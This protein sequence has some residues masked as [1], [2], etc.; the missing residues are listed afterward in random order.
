MNNISHLHKTLYFQSSF[1]YIISFQPHKNPV[2]CMW[3]IPEIRCDKGQVFM[4]R[5]PPPQTANLTEKIIHTNALQRENVCTIQPRPTA[6]PHT[7]CLSQLTCV[8]WGLL[9]TQSRLTKHHL[10]ILSAVRA[11]AAFCLSDPMLGDLHSNKEQLTC[12]TTRHEKKLHSGASWDFLW[13][14]GDPYF[15]YQGESCPFSL[16]SVCEWSILLL[17]NVCYC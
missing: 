11:S 9:P 17:L 7:R 1:T 5:K 6:I 13:W 8:C 4:D 10:L 12:F 14:G 16:R 3:P 15:S 2:R